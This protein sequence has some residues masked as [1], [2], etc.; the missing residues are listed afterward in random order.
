MVCGTGSKNNTN[1]LASIIISLLLAVIFINQEP[2]IQFQKGLLEHELIYIIIINVALLCLAMT[3]M[4][5]NKIIWFICWIIYLVFNI[6]SILSTG[7]SR[8]I[9]MPFAIIFKY[10]S[11]IM[12][13][14]K[15]NNIIRWIAVMI[16]LLV[17]GF[18][19]CN[20]LLK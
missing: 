8:I 6:Y 18:A 4:I 13:R 17:S 7:I 12:L 1:L 11:K 16:P 20:K 14:P 15:E 5:N 9:L 2:L 19:I 3:R 10:I